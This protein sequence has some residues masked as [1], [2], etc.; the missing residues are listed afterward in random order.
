MG[1]LTG[2]GPGWADYQ[3]RQQQQRP[4]QYAAAQPQAMPQLPSL[5]PAP[6]GQP[7]GPDPF[8]PAP[9]APPMQAMPPQKEM[10]TQD[11]S[12][13]TGFFGR[14]NKGFG[15]LNESPLFS[16]GMSLLGNAQGSNWAGVGQ[17]MRQFGQDQTERQRMQN[18][19]RR[20]KTADVRD[21]TVFGRQQQE[22]GRQDTQRQSLEQWIATLPPEQ[23]VVAR[24][25][26][27]AAHSAY[28]EAQA[29]ANTPITPYQ[30]A[31]LDLERRGQSLSYGAQMANINRDR[32]M[33]G[34]DASL[35]SDVREAAARSSA[36]SQLG[37]TFMELNG[38]GGT[39]T[40]PERRYNPFNNFDSG[41][42]T[43]NSV[44]SQMIPFMRAPGSGATSDYEQQLY[45]RG[46]QSPT[47]SPQA[48]QEIYRNQQ[49]LANIAQQRRYFYEDYASQNGTLNGAEQAFQSSPQFQQI[50]RAN[51]MQQQ[52][53]ASAPAGGRQ[54]SASGSGITPEQARA[55]LRRRENER[56]QRG[57]YGNQ[58]GGYTGR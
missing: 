20:L 49:A 51:P 32:P 18:E 4:I 50:T 25:N 42:Q 16:L 19:E 56:R 3:R 57:A 35:L 24:A 31:Q 8:A 53:P 21:E 5:T 10:P 30:Q 2:Y 45:Q 37:G 44:V 33:R 11:P 40:G 52:A 28:M 36:L 23:Q 14:L 48:N 38:P 9:V 1:L 58:P 17:D 27:E 29:N 41:Y 54:P 15:S 22:W 7:M 46:V 39:G 6:S 34:P 55:E 43:M 47:N 26:P 13:N 12:A